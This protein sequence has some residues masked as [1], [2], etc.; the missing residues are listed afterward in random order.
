MD[1][2]KFTPE[3][4]KNMSTEHKVYLGLGLVAA[5][6]VYYEWQKHSGPSAIQPPPSLPTAFGQAYQQ[7]YQQGK[8]QANQPLSPQQLALAA[9]AG[10]QF[11]QMPPT[12]QAAT[13]ISQDT[14]FEQAFDVMRLA[15]GQAL[16]SGYW[17]MV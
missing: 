16:T 17:G 12:Q 5:V 3:F 10:Q 15:S 4:L 6:L 11:Q 9:K 1:I 2:A 7:G 8:V 14:P 13:V